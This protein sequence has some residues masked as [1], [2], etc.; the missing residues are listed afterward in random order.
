MEHFVQPLLEYG[1]L[2]LATAISLAVNV[3]LYRAGVKKDERLLE[4]AYK[5]TD[6]AVRT[7]EQLFAAIQALQDAKEAIYG[8]GRNRGHE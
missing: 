2:G 3:A 1:V 8:S 4:G 7:A 6:D 5:R